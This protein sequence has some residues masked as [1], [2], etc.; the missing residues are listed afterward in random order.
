MV[1]AAILKKSK[2]AISP[3]RLD[4]FAQNL[5]FPITLA[6]RFYNSLYY[7]TSRDDHNTSFRAAFNAC[8]YNTIVSK[9]NKIFQQT[10]TVAR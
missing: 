2:T 9:V 1:D 6:S 7:R 5:A 4:R 10:C 8:Y 3:Q